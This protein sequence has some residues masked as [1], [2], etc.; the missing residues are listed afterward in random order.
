MSVLA[1]ISFSRV[2]S[3]GSLFWALCALLMLCHCHRSAG[4]QHAKNHDFVRV[5]QFY[6]GSA[7]DA[8]QKPEAVI[9]LIEKHLR[10][11][12]IRSATI[13]DLGAGSGYFTF[14]LLDR[15][16]RVKALENDDS[17]LTFLKDRGK[18]HAK[19]H[20][21]E[22][23]RAEA[24]GSNLKN[25]EVDI[26]LTVNVYHH[27]ENRTA[28]FKNL[29]PAFRTADGLL[30]IVDTKDGDLP[31]APP[32]DI[33]VSVSTVVQELTEAGYE[34]SVD[35]DTLPYQAIFLARPKGT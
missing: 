12:K 35:N 19:N 20:N 16:H 29:K 27:M 8:W 28:Y 33:R 31:L 6:E 24:G 23:R 21:L 10:Q 5:L 2:F 7:R 22:V 34:V 32:P 25:G 30:V 1:Q 4:H 13:A 9:Q 26:V 3:L 15:G 17:F 14:R 11:A 18:S